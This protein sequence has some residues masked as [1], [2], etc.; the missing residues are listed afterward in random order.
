M[1][2]D[3]AQVVGTISHMEEVCSTLQHGVS[4]LNPA[5]NGGAVKPTQPNKQYGVAMQM[6]L[7]RPEIE[8]QI[9]NMVW[10]RRLTP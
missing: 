7:G 2:Q 9:P 3:A 8:W 10:R 4:A 1:A 6:R 5:G